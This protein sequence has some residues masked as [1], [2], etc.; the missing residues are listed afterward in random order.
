MNQYDVIIVGA[1]PAGATAAKILAEN[2]RR[3]L[4][5]DQKKSRSDKP[6]GGGLPT[7]VLKRF[8]YIEPFIDSTSYGSVMY[9][10]SLRYQYRMVR[11][12]P[13]LFMVQ[14]KMFDQGLVDLAVQS[15]A[16]FRDQTRVVDLN[17]MKD[18]AQIIL[19][20]GEVITS[21]LV[22]ACDGVRSVVAEKICLSTNRDKSC[23]CLFLEVPVSQE[24]LDRVY[25]KKRIA[26]IFIK[27]Q[28]IAGYGWV[29]PKKNSIN[30]GLGEFEPAVDPCKDK[31]NIK[32]LF[33]EFIQSL[34]EKNI[35]PSDIPL[36]DV[37][38]GLL[39]VF[40]LEKT[41]SDRVLLCGDAAGFVNPITGEGIY[42]AMVSGELAAGITEQAIQQNNTSQ[43]FLSRYQKQWKREFGND[44]IM[45]GRFNKQWGK[46]SE[47]I[48]RFITLDKTFAKL[49]IGIMGGQLSFSKYKYLLFLRYFYVSFKDKLFPSH[50]KPKKR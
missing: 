48:V 12:T 26:H 25:T 41:Y 23:V 17:I 29:F 24:Q 18:H 50:T 49:T 1:G 10:S 27:T 11:D 35:I 22:L 45:L 13:F 19:E 7:R 30:I 9:S 2:K 4:L 32:E 3:V 46:D 39:P 15:G 43:Q 8:P 47:K 36:G 16:T 20:N 31:R 21:N 33:E 37:K 14:R 42:Y 6:C 38:G 40:P 44:L 5:L 34:T 28:K